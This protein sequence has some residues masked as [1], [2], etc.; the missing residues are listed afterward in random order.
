[1]ITDDVL[2][3][4]RPLTKIFIR[5]MK[6]TVSDHHIEFVLIGRKLI[7]ATGS[8]S[9]FLLKASCDAHYV[10]IYPRYSSRVV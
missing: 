6:L 1:M 3:S 2:L 10:V 4:I 8:D 5:G 9:S 7:E